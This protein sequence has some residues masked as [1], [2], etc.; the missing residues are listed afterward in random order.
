MVLLL[1][2]NNFSLHLLKSSKKGLKKHLSSYFM[3]LHGRP[4]ACLKSL[5]YLPGVPLF[6]LPN[7]TV[8]I[9]PDNFVSKNSIPGYIVMH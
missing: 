7:G 9:R 4:K 1:F 8:Y 3:T 6:P 2:F 5:W